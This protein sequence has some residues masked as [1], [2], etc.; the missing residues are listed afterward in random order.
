MSDHDE[1]GRAASA[2]DDPAPRGL[3][4]RT[5]GV[6]DVVAGVTEAAVGPVRPPPRWLRWPQVWW[7]RLIALVVAFGVGFG[8]F[9]A[10]LEQLEALGLGSFPAVLLA[11]A[12]TLALLTVSVAPLLGWRWL[13]LALLVGQV[14]VPPG[15][16][17]WPVT[18]MLFLALVVSLVAS[19]HPRRVGIG[20]WVLTTAV[21][22]VPATA[23]GRVPLPIVVVLSAVVAVVVL[24]GDTVRDRR[25]VR[26]RLETAAVQRRQDLARQAVLEERSHIARELHDVVA[27]HMSMIAVQAEA[28]P[29]RYPDLSPEVTQT[30]TVIRDASRE[31]LGEMRR[32]VGVLR[33]DDE[34]ADRT[35]IPGTDQ[36]TALVEASRRAG[37]GVELEVFGDVRPLPAAVDVSVYRVVQEALSNARRHASGAL[38]QV[39][40]GYLPDRLTVRVVDDG[41]R[42]TARG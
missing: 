38:V 36:V 10:T 41:G 42:V 18:S 23:V 9:V 31:A 11:A 1:T 4:L 2:P 15:D 35:P 13:C 5:D 39:E 17:P 33:S 7:Q 27:H 34:T 40:I 3:G 24:F 12:Q 28:A 22:L 21:V 19:T 16:W 29:L 32:V 25:V 20:V 26:S 8:L 6:A 14:L 30:F 37:M